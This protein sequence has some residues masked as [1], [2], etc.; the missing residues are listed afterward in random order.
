L[1]IGAG[2]FAR[3]Q[4]ARELRFVDLNFVETAA[5]VAGTLSLIAAALGGAGAYAFATFLLVS[6]AVTT[7]LAWRALGWRPRGPV[8]FS[9]IRS[10]LRTGLNLTAYHT[11]TY[12]QQQLDTY[13]IGA[14]FGPRPL[15]LYSRSTQ[16]L[17]LPNQHLAAPLTQ[18]A[19]AT[20]SRLGPHS[21]QFRAEARQMAAMIAHFTLPVASLC[22]ALPAEVVALVLGQQWPEAAPMLRWLA[23]SAAITACTA[24]AYGVNVAAGQAPRLM[25]V[26]LATLPVT[27]IAIGFGLGHG[28]VAVATALAVANF[29]LAAPRLAWMLHGSPVRMWDYLGALMGALQTAAAFGAGAIVSARLASNAPSLVRLLVG[30]VGGAVA[31]TAL[32]FASRRIRAEWSYLWDHL[33]TL[34][35]K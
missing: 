27:L 8:Q 15:G 22:I 24:L 26:S 1:L 31:A 35:R 28:P 3:A 17:A 18:V 21:P 30:L 29:V 6:E 32:A 5:A 25:H 33:P 12:A 19:L 16:I 14:A 23:V 9:S 13:A 4:L 10:L 2:G 20:L 34:R 11:I 7:G